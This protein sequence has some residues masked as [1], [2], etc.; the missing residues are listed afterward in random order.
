MLILLVIVLILALAT[1]PVYPYSRGWGYLPERH[2]GHHP[3][4]HLDSLLA[5]RLLKDVHL[6]LLHWFK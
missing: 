4:H 1:A 3:A 6:S 2:S 5:E